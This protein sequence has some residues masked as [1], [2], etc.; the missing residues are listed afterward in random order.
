MLTVQILLLLGTVLVGLVLFA[1]EIIPTDVT[2]LGILLFLTIAGLLP[3]E[4]AFAGFGSDAVI[5]ILGI[6][7]MVEAL[8]RTGVTD[9]VGRVILRQTDTSANKI[10]ACGD[11]CLGGDGGIHKQYRSDC[12]FPPHR[13]WLGSSGKAQPGQ[14]PDAAGICLGPRQFYH[15]D[16]YLHQRHRQQPDHKIRHAADGHV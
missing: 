5:M 14:V 11:D 4:K 7:V 8:I 12:V 6:L 2:A 13:H 3:V 15:A 16:Q 9:F 10:L 1:L